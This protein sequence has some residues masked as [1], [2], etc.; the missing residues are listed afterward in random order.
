[1]SD[2]LG[3]VD[4]AIGLVDSVLHLPHGQ[5]KFLGRIF[6]EIQFTEVLLEM[7]ME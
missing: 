5:V 7:G 4:F 1:M 6:K 2:S 3:P